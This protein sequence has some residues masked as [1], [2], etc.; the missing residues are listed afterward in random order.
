MLEL[1]SL[2]TFVGGGE[3]D[4]N[5]YQVLFVFWGCACSFVKASWSK[6]SQNKGTVKES[7][8]EDKGRGREH[9]QK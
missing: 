6:T 8:I 3:R 9:R 5:S 2:G 1:A 7:C 4:C